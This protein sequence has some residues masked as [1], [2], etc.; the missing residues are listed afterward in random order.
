MTFDHG[1]LNSFQKYTCWTYE[2]K[3]NG[4][5]ILS[6]KSQKMTNKLSASSSLNIKFIINFIFHPLVVE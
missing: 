5:S 1:V 2:R 3:T 6:N 4:S